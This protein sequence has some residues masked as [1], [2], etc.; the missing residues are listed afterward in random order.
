MAPRL[1]LLAIVAA[2]AL[3]SAVA[4]ASPS[5]PMLI[6]QDLGLTCS[7]PPCT[8]CHRDNNGGLGTVVTAFGRSMMGF[9]LVAESP[10]A[11]KSALEQEE[12][13]HTDSNGDGVTD[14]AALMACEDPNQVQVGDGGAGEGGGANSELNVDPT[15]EYGCAIGRAASREGAP[16]SLAVGVGV[17]VAGTRRRRARSPRR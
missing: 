15:P 10:A 13:T 12:Q 3:R 8:I 1:S 17:V 11:L 16:W 4:E 14:I 2:L 5:Y 7:P 6:E 9:G